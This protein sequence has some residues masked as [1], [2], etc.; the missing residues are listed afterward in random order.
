MV[1]GALKTNDLPTYHS[2]WPRYTGIKPGG[3]CLFDG[4]QSYS[5]G[6]HD[7]VM[8]A[9]NVSSG[10]GPGLCSAYAWLQTVLYQDGG[11][12]WSGCWSNLGSIVDTPCA[13]TVSVP[14]HDSTAHCST[15][16]SATITCRVYY[17]TII[18]RLIDWLLVF[19]AQSTMTVIS[20][21]NT[22]C[23]NNTYLKYP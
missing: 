15:P 22:V 17:T 16:P 7:G 4:L 13:Y 11:N 18:L 21:R 5:E 8:F 14:D 20:G 6:H 3:L 9:A 2:S 10:K 12:L 1:N 19:N 23:L